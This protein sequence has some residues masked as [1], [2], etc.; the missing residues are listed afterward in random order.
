MKTKCSI[1]I[2]CIGAFLTVAAAQTLNNRIAVANSRASGAALQ[3]ALINHGSSTELIMN[4]D[5]TTNQE[6]SGRASWDYA[7]HAN[8]VHCAGIRLHIFVQ[9]PQIASQYNIY[10]K[11]ASTWYSATFTP[12][13]GNAWENIFIPKTNFFPEGDP[14]SW[15]NC[16][17]LRIAAWKGTPG[18]LSIHLAELEFVRPNAS[19]AILRSGTTAAAVKESY[20]YAKI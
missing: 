9:N 16:S 20:R 18:K 7:V 19:F 6:I 15:T 2:F 17:M 5:F 1:I 3:P 12:K 13:K 10:L 11:F 8:L 14:E 4:A